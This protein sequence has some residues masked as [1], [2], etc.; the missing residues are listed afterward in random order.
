MP[1]GKPTENS[2]ATQ[3]DR[4]PL[5]ESFSF[6]REKA[7]DRLHLRLHSSKSGR[8]WSVAAKAAVVLL[9]IGVWGLLKTAFT[10][11]DAMQ[12]AGTGKLKL[13]IEARP[14][15]NGFAVSTTRLQ[16]NNEKQKVLTNTNTQHTA[17]QED[18]QT[19]ERLVTANAIYKDTTNI[20]ASV[21]PLHVMPVAKKKLPVVYNNEIARTENTD[22]FSPMSESNNTSPL[23]RK[24]YTETLH[25]AEQQE[26][27][28]ENIRNRWMPFNKSA[29]PKE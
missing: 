12:I 9:L 4:L 3:L 18:G 14:Q 28:P 24:S 23:P 6:D 21:P 20:S 1:T 25:K 17:A 11:S 19:E 7:W 26:T 27:V 13:R 15:P 8:R 22:E 10:G 2:K 5:P 29:K 16:E